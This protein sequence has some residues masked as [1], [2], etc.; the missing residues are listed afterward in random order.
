MWFGAE[1]QPELPKREQRKKCWE[2]RDLYFA[3][4]DK[5]GIINPFDPSKTKQIKQNCGSEDVQF[6]KDCIA[7]W[8]KYFKEKRPFDLKK[9]KL[10][11]EAANQGQE[12]VQMPGYKK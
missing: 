2:S 10:L 11:S 6:Q 4:L 8:V 3:C 7:S 5:E 12:I 1:K 9:E